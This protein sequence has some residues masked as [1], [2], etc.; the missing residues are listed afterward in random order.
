MSAFAHDAGSDDSNNVLGRSSIAIRQDKI[1][2]GID[3]YSEQQLLHMGSILADEGFG[4]FDRCMMVLRSLRGDIE[5]ARKLLSSITF[6][7]IQIA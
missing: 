6:T 4:S 1:D 2:S 3:V 7:E 5:K